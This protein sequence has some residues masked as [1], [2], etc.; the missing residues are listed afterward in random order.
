MKGQNVGYIRVSS[1]SQNTERQLAD[2][3]LDRIFTDKASGK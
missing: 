1:T 3:A 2:V